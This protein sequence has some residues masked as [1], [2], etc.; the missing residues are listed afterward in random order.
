MV[1]TAAY[2][3]V[4]ITHR[5][6]RKRTLSKL[7]AFDLVVAIT[8]GSTMANVLLSRTVSLMGVSRRWGC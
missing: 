6:S 4:L 2:V 8:L 5:I 1:G 7:N 3:F